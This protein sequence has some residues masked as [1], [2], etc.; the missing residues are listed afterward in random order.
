VWGD[1]AYDKEWKA[2]DVWLSL[3]RGVLSGSR[4][5]IVGVHGVGWRLVED[6]RA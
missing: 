3:I 1:L 4:F 5:K 2:I 6:E